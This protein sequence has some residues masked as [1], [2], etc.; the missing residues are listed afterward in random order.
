MQPDLSI[1][2][3]RS[4]LDEKGCNGAPDLI[5]EVLSKST[6]HYDRGHKLALYRAA[7]VQVC[8]LIDPYHES[9]EVYDFKEDPDRFFATAIYQNGTD[10]HIPVSIVE[11]F[12]I[13]ITD[14]FTI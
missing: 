12:T 1:I 6:A 10:Q 3:D 13:Q 14:L 7:G 9:I 8:W 4:K 5:V 2:C 11:S